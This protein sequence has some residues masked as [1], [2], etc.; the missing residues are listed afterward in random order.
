MTEDQHNDTAQVVEK[1]LQLF[2]EAPEAEH[3]AEQTRRCDKLIAL[4][5]SYVAEQARLAM[6]SVS[7][8]SDSTALDW[9]EAIQEWAENLRNMAQGHCGKDAFITIAEQDSLPPPSGTRIGRPRDPL[10][11]FYVAP[12]T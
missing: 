12:F 2:E 4:E 8:G 9:I 11:T 5:A 1:T 10:P 3:V 6:R 7:R